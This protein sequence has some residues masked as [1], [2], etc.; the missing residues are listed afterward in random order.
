MANNR[1][2]C[3]QCQHFFVT[4]DASFPRGC[5]GYGFRCKTM[6]ALEVL[7]ASGRECL[8]F[9][10]KSPPNNEKKRPV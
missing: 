2:N 6:P 3:L 5:R 7:Q 4:W 9:S 10:P 8:M 1:P